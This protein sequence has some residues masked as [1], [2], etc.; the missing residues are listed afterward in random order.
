M[1]DKQDA[2]KYKAKCEKQGLNYSDIPKEAI[3][4]FIGE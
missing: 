4:K 1:L 3:L 2:E